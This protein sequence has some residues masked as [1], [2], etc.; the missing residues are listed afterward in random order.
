MEQVYIIGK[1][2]ERG[3][4]E[5]LDY[6]FK[7][8]SESRKVARK[9]IEKHNKNIYYQNLK[10]SIDEYLSLLREISPD[11]WVSNTLTVS[12]EVMKVKELMS[13]KRIKSK[14]IKE[15]KGEFLAQEILM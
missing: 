2:D 7:D 4:T 15:T 5:F 8:Y 10:S 1:T 14:L 12:I 9:L 13:K 3:K 11:V 6:V